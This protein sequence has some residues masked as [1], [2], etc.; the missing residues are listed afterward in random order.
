MA[1]FSLNHRT[2]GRSTHKPRTASFNAR[3][4]T[5]PRSCTEILGARMP[6]DREELFAWLDREE[7]SDRRNAR[8][9]DKVIIALPI[10]LSH[11][12]N[13]ELVEAYAE[14]M[15]QGRASWVAGIHDGPGDAHNP[16]AHIL[17]R[18]RDFETG[19]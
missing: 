7:A 1:I 6:T 16:H 2:V 13:V 9:I 18:D 14:R 11:D 12:Q 15:T 19:K 5:N 10:E 4:V 3:Y 8:V 17:F